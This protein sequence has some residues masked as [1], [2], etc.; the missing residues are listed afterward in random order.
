MGL[1]RS[2]A[3]GDPRFSRPTRGRPGAGCGVLCGYL[4]TVT[5]TSVKTI[6]MTIDE[7]LLKL[8]DKMS[9]DRKTSR[10]AFIRDALQEEIRR[11]QIRGNEIRHTEGYA[12]QPV[13]RGEFDVWISEQDWGTS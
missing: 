1:M 8:V 2:L 9:R 11:E 4:S 7:G 10:S 12:R 5:S 3:L 13:A 6:Q